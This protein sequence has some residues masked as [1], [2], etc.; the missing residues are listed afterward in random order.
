MPEKCEYPYCRDG[1]VA[2]IYLGKKLCWRCWS[3]TNKMTSD[4]YK[5]KLKLKE[6]KRATES[7][8][9]LLA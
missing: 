2:I 4:E 6:K 9:S 5:A 1:E 8:L 7:R 3:K